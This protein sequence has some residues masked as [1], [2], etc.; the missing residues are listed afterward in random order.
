MP[1]L[2]ELKE[3]YKQVAEL[4]YEEDIDEKTILD[5]LESIEGEIEDKADNYARMIKN[6]NGD[7]KKFKEEKDRLEKR[8][9]HFEKRAEILKDRL[10]QI[11]RETGKTKFST[12]LFGFNIQK[13]GGL[14]PLNIFGVV[15]MEFMK[16][17]PDNIKIREA[18]EIKELGFAKIEERGDSLRIR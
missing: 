8:Q 17:E 12:E 16:F 9:K 13:N 11:M 4:L 7:A 10:E 18:L 6:L 5:T 14:A 1:T 3:N 15:P 2:Y